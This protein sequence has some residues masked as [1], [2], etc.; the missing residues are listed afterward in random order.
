MFYGASFCGLGLNNVV[1]RFSTVSPHFT[2]FPRLRRRAVNP[3]VLSIRLPPS[4]HRSFAQRP[5][6]SFIFPR[7]SS[8]HRSQFS[9]TPLPPSALPGSLVHLPLN[10]SSP[11]LKIQLIPR[12]LVERTGPRRILTRSPLPSN[13][14]E[15][16]NGRQ[17]LPIFRARPAKNSAVFELFLGS[18]VVKDLFLSVV[19][20]SLILF[21]R[22]WV[23]VRN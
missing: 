7:L 3:A 14:S 6:T 8:L 15:A 13:P 12:R 1:P 18:S 19:L 4:R 9:R 5:D 10:S 21:C 16:F 23:G 20:S 2:P 17:H 22:D 11:V